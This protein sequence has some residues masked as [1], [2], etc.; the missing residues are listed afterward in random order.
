MQANETLEALR[1]EARALDIEVDMRWGAYR[2]RQEIER[3]KA[4]KAESETPDPDGTLKTEGTLVNVGS[5]AAPVYQRKE[6]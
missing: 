6:D 3:R 5:T 2:L 4:E 1:A